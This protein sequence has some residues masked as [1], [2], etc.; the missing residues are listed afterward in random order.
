MNEN[1]M[2][3]ILRFSMSSNSY[4]KFLNDNYSENKEIILAIVQNELVSNH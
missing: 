4:Q 1:I 2:R 3:F